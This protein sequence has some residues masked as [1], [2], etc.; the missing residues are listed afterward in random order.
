M[1]NFFKRNSFEELRQVYELL[2]ICVVMY[3]SVIGKRKFNVVNFFEY[4][5]FEE[6]RQAYTLEG[7]CSIIHGAVIGSGDSLPDDK[8]TLCKNY[9]WHKIET[10]ESSPLRCTKYD[11]AVKNLVKETIAEI[12]AYESI[13]R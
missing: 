4:N 2:H 6:I 5:S 10:W 12:N 8:L 1:I 7:L 3:D 13:A 11:E 9:L